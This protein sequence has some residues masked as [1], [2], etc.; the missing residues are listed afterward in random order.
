MLVLTD[1][2]SVFLR[3][4]RP[5]SGRQLT[6][7]LFEGV[8]C[9]KRGEGIGRGAGIERKVPRRDGWRLDGFFDYNFFSAHFSISSCPRRTALLGRREFVCECESCALVSS[10][11]F[12]RQASNQ[13]AVDNCGAFQDNSLPRTLVNLKIARTKQ[14]FYRTAGRTRSDLVPARH[15]CCCRRGQYSCICGCCRRRQSDNF[16]RLTQ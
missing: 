10:R 13:Q 12:A 4:A 7:R 1:R 2:E 15:C 6:G 14:S 5:R 9:C 8:A 11:Q 3:A 16:Q